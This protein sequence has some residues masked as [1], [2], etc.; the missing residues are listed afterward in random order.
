MPIKSSRMSLVLGQWSVKQTML[1]LL[2]CHCLCPAYAFAHTMVCYLLAVRVLS[3]PWFQWS[4]KKTRRKCLNIFSLPCGTACWLLGCVAFLSTVLSLGFM[5]MLRR[6]ENTT[7]THRRMK[8][9]KL[10]WHASRGSVPLQNLR[11]YSAVDGDCPFVSFSHGLASVGSKVG[12]RKLRKVAW[13]LLRRDKC[14]QAGWDCFLPCSGLTSKD[15]SEYFNETRRPGCWASLLEA[16]VLA[17]AFQVNV[18][19]ANG[20]T[21]KSFSPTA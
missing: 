15:W 13:Q 19:V 6:L 11:P 7:R 3:G 4:R 12:P 9:W 5:F 18:C 21:T 2:L 20:D 17:E 8:P 10:R 1:M 14:V 16:K